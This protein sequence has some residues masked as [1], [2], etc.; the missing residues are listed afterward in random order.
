MGPWTSTM[1]TMTER[2]WTWQRRYDEQ[3]D[4]IEE[5]EV[6]IGELQSQNPQ[7]PAGE[8]SGRQYLIACSGNLMKSTISATES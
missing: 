8:D 1:H 2:F 7:H 4:T 5:I 3:Y 6:Q